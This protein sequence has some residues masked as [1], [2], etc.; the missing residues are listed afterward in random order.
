MRLPWPGGLSACSVAYSLPLMAWTAFWA[1]ILYGLLPSR[2]KPILIMGFSLLN[3]LFPPSVDL[4][5]FLPCHSVIPAVVL[6][7][8]CLLGLF[9][10]YCMLFFHLIIVT[11]NCHW[12]HIHATSGFLD[13]FHCL[14]A[15]LAHFFLLRHPRPISFPWASSA[16]SNFAFPWA[17]ANSFGLPRLNYHIL[18]FWGSWALHQPL[19]HLLHYFGHSLAHSAFHTAHGFTT[20]FSGLL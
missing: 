8:P 17:F 6:F 16:H 7:D 19:T 11:Q 13:P 18:C 10:T 4:L 14:W 5:A 15:S 3:P 9:W 1:F 2:A 20:F 12:V